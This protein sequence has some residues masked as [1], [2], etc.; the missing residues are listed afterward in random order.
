[1]ADGETLETGK[2]RFRFL[3]TAQLP[4][5]WDAGLLYEETRADAPLLGPL[6]PER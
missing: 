2:Y 6:P 3:R 1:M 4:H 5:G